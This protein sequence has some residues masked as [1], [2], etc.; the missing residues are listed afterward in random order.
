M[1]PKFSK[2]F[3]AVSLL[4]NHTSHSGKPYVNVH[5][6]VSFALSVPV[7]RRRE[8][9]VLSIRYREIPVRYRMETKERPNSG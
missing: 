2:K 6:F 5:Y 9:K 1:V 4:H 7:L 3:D 8:G